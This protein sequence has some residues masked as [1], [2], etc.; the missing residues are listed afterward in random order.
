MKRILLFMLLFLT[1]AVMVGAQAQVN[2][3]EAPEMAMVAVNQVGY[4]VD[5]P[6]YGM[7]AASTSTAT[8]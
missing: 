1:L 5:G 3:V 2:T 8:T 7:L 4:F 6:K